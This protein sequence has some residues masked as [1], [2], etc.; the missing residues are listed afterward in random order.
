MPQQHHRLSLKLKKMWLSADSSMVVN[1]QDQEAAGSILLRTD[2]ALSDVKVS[3]HHDGDSVVKLALK[4]RLPNSRMG[5]VICQ[6]M[7]STS[8]L[9]SRVQVTHLASRGSWRHLTIDIGSSSTMLSSSSFSSFVVF[10]FLESEIQVMAST[11]SLIRSWQIHMNYLMVAHSIRHS[12]APENLTT[13]YTITSGVMMDG[14][15]HH[16]GPGDLSGIKSTFSRASLF[17]SLMDEITI[18]R[19]QTPLL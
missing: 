9:A 15:L 18:F 3:A 8:C 11:G 2:V 13:T 4:S 10:K 14:H 7:S 1:S 16:W 19:N 5:L 6:I 12:S 17:A